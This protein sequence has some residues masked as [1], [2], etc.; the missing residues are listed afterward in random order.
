MSN[1]RQYTSQEDFFA[2]STFIA[3][4]KEMLE[5]HTFPQTAR[6]IRSAMPERKFSDHSIR[7]VLKLAGIGLKAPSRT[8]GTKRRRELGRLL[9][10]AMRLVVRSVEKETGMEPGTLSL[11]PGGRALVALSNARWD[12]LESL[13]DEHDHLIKENSARQTSDT[14]Q[15]KLFGE[16]NK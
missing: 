3:Q 9:G 6:M 14:Q 10:K 11:T 4:N 1:S 8:G 5:G 16:E 7:K 2:L 15:P 12:E 13:I